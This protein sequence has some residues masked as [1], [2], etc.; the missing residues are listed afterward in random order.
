MGRVAGYPVRYTLLLLDK[1]L[2]GKKS[3]SVHYLAVSL[4]L[5][6]MCNNKGFGMVIE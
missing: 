2:L 5:S 3:H 6:G 1:M 4:T